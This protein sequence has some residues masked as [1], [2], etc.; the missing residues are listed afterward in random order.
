VKEVLQLSLQIALSVA[1]PALVIR[2]DIERLAALRLS[3]AW[4]D[5]SF[6]SAVVAFGPI[7]LIVHFTRTRRSLLGLTLGLVWALGNLVAS[8]VVVSACEL[9]F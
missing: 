2:W 9:M 6:W 8:A 5:A 4:N 3:R 1:F 7:S